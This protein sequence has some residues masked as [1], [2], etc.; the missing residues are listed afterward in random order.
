MGNADTTPTETEGGGV[1]SSNPAVD[2]GRK[3]VVVLA[4]CH[5]FSGRMTLLSV[6]IERGKNNH[7]AGWSLT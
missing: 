5:V 6:Q 2:D 7:V 4:S 3:V 1:Y